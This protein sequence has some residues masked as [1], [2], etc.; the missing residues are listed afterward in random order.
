M[1]AEPRVGHEQM[2][3]RESRPE[4]PPVAFSEHVSVRNHIV[5]RSE[6]EAHHLAAVAFA[7]ELKVGALLGVEIAGSLS[8]A[9]VYV[10][11]EGALPL[12]GGS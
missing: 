8:N 7:E 6:R 1:N 5:V 10:P 3:A 9:L 2:F 11:K 12:L 4:Q